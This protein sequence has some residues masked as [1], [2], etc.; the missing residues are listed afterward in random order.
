MENVDFV[1]PVAD[2]VVKKVFLTELGRTQGKFAKFPIRV[3]GVNLSNNG[4]Y[5]CWDVPNVISERYDISK[6]KIEPG[7]LNLLTGYW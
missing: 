1:A 3:E 2:W 7:A 4:Q 6:A 5:F